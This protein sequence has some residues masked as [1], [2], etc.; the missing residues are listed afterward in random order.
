M[1]PLD[2]VRKYL[3]VMTQ[4][5]QKFVEHVDRLVSM[6]WEFSLCDIIELTIDL[7]FWYCLIYSFFVLF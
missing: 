6:R 7:K 4:T 1:M 3:S 2:S 5:V